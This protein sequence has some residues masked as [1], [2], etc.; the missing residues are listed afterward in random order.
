MKEIIN[1][2]KIFISSL[3]MAS[4]EQVKL[5]TS[6]QNSLNQELPV[7]AYVQCTF[8]IKRNVVAEVAEDGGNV[9]AE[10]GI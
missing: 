1:P 10:R 3:L 8:T 7:P 2:E 5:F 9:F 4:V 6:I